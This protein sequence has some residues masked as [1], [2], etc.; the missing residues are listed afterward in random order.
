MLSRRTGA[1]LL[2]RRAGAA[3][4][5]RRI[6]SVRAPPGLCTLA[7]TRTLA[8]ASA[9]ADL[10]AVYLAERLEPQGVHKLA[11]VLPQTKIEK[12]KCVPLSPLAK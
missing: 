9:D 11:E 1:A 2:S 4:L 7:A 6:A 10:P 3:M 12:L 5:S 8:S